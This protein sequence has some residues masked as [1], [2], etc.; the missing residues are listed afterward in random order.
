MSRSVQRPLQSS[1][2]QRSDLAP[3]TTLAFA[4][5]DPVL[6]APDADSL[7]ALLLGILDSAIALAEADFGNMQL[8]DPEGRL[9]IV[10]HRGFEPEWIDYWNA[11]AREG[12]GACGAA[13]EQAERVI[14]EDV[15]ESPIFAC[16]PDASTTPV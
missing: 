8:I 1:P 9:R 10:V 2:F 3:M 16:A 7:N 12:H 11:A 14:V 5:A 15:L 13:L 6:P 4:P